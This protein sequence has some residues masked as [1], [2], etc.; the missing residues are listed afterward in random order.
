MDAARKAVAPYLKCQLPDGRFHFRQG[1][2]QLDSNGQSIWTLWQYYRITG[3]RKWLADVYPKMRRGAD[4][5]IAACRKAPADS[6][7][8]GL[9]PPGP[10]DGECLWSGK[11]HIVGYDLWNLR[12]VLCTVDAAR[13]L[14]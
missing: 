5:T 8:A 1:R 10:A 3:D 4:W 9:L 13:E 6:P 12:G 7:F 14:G 11:Y 2:G